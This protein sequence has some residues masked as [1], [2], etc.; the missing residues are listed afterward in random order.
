M[1]D[2][3]VGRGMRVLGFNEGDMD[4]PNEFAGGEVEIPVARAII[5]LP[6]GHAS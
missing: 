5:A 4:G 3:S 6:T 1:S 2:G